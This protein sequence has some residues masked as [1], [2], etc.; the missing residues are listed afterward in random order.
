MISKEDGNIIAEKK[1]GY[2]LATVPVRH[3]EKIYFGS[4]DKK[5]VVLSALDGHP[6]AETIVKAIPTIVAPSDND[7]VYFGD[8]RGYVFAL[9]EPS[10]KMLWSSVTGAEISDMTIIPQGLLVSSND[11]YIYL[12]S[13][14]NGN[15]IWKRRLAGRAVGKPLVRDETGVFSSFGSNEAIFL[16]LRRGK[17]VNQFFIAGDNYFI[18]NPIVGT[19]AASIIFPTLRDFSA[20]DR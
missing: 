6:V 3:R 15:R 13:T 5:I 11:N 20:C 9:R 16:N 10:K 19:E 7:I 14:K 2:N 18:G 1:L 12:L 17:V 4:S 8:K